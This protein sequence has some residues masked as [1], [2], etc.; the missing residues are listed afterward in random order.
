MEIG[1]KEVDEKVPYFGYR[2][3]F[4]HYFTTLVCGFYVEIFSKLI[5]C[6]FPV[7]LYDVDRDEGLRGEL[8]IRS[9]EASGYTANLEK[10]ESS[11]KQE[12]N[13]FDA[14][15]QKY[16]RADTAYAAEAHFVQSYG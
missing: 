12:S 14:L 8:R 1:C 2:R 9:K 6:V 5:L 13:D 7:Y 3:R 10:D 11:S 15:L 16:T 4:A